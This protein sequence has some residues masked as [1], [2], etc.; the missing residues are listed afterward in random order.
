MTALA[1]SVVLALVSA[2]CYAAGA[3]LQE[4]VAA[5]SP[6]RPYAPVR[7][8]SW[9]AAVALNG[10]GGV[11]HV[12]ALAYGPLSVVQPLGALT[13]VF[14]LPMA[15]LFVRRKVSA[16]GWRGAVLA[17]AG[18]AGLLS[19][20][21]PAPA[22]ALADAERIAVTVAT[23]ALVAV[24]AGGARWV[25]R[26]GVRSVLLAAAAGTAF[27]IS[28]VFTKNV[29][30]AWAWDAWA[31]ALP[32]LVM[33]GLLA[34]AGV[35]LSQSAY[36]GAGLAAP[37]ATATVVNPVVATGVGVAALGEHFRL[38]LAGTLLA[39]G[40]AAVATAGL[41]LLTTEGPAQPAE[42]AG[43]EAM[44]SAGSADAT[45][46]TAGP[47][48]GPAAGPAGPTI[49]PVEPTTDPAGSPARLGSAAAPAGST[50]PATPA[51]VAPGRIAAVPVPR[52]RPAEESVEEPGSRSG[53]LPPP[54][55]P[56]AP[57]ASAVP[58]VSSAVPQVA[59]VANALRLVGRIGALGGNDREDFDRASRVLQER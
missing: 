57:T 42:A 59:Q 31:E 41:A 26:P 3:I 30:V 10:V 19:L 5:T 34:S 12:L 47:T 38:G 1:L 28:S 27:G 21:G 49:A 2:V 8:G 43:V 7:R 15:A 32:S 13:I 53:E 40:T 54:T 35:F 20:T 16:T 39:L 17:T 23:V 29:A 4:H 6:Q 25:R 46:P 51:E 48:A 37:L 33:I 45:G 52:A 14:A 36:R 24:L 11:L 58:P 22:E 18:L 9:W 55:L 56:A 44:G 50:P